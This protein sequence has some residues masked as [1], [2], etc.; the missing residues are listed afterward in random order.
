MPKIDY[1]VYRSI[2]AYDRRVRHLIMH[3][4]A[5]DFDTSIHSLTVKGQVSA[6][7]LVP[8]P[9]DA[10]YKAHEFKEYSVFNLVDENDRAF[11][12]GQS[13][14][15]GVNNINYSSIGIE[16]VNVPKGEPPVF[17]PYHPDQIK[18]VRELA[19]AI[20]ALYPEITP[21][22]VLGHSDIAYMR[23]KDPGP[24]FPWYE[25]Y[26]SGVGAWPEDATKKK[27]ADY[28]SQHGLPPQSE[29]INAFCRHG[30]EAPDNSDPESWR[31]LVRAFQMHFRQACYDGV[32]DVETCAVL[33]ALNER[34]HPPKPKN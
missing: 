10:T 1:H 7:Y 20:V 4:T 26:L 33:Y 18:A 28:F 22:R 31:N 15:E 32:M 27:Y 8:D 11:H 30:Y 29:L 6:H 14:W 12:A 16:I 21:T 19:Q 34:Y 23:K 25:L 13:S 2:V 17:P 3:Y 24:C 5:E 9:T